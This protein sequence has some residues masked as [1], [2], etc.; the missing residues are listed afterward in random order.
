MYDDMIDAH[1]LH[2]EAIK[3]YANIVS[4][5]S[6]LVKNKISNLLSMNLPINMI[7]PSHGVI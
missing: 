2:N 6:G 5:Y 1:M 3:Y 4:P 7:A